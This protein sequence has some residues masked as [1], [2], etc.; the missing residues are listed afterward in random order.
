M[1]GFCVELLLGAQVFPLGSPVDL[2][3]LSICQKNGIPL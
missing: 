2:I 1:W 3:S